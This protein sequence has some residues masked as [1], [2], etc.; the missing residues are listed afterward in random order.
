M[1]PTIPH[2]HAQKMSQIKIATGLSVKRNP[3]T[4]GVTIWTLDDFQ[5][6]VDSRRQQYPAKARKSQ[7]GYKGHNRDSNQR[8]DIRKEDKKSSHH[9]PEQRVRHPDEVHPTPMET[10]IRILIMVTV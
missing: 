2:I 7:E 6:D 10:P 4:I 3:S 8:P 9:S 1:A 5:G